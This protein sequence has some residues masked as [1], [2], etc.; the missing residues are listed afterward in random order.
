[1]FRGKMVAILHVNTLQLSIEYYTQVLGFTV[2]NFVDEDGSPVATME[3]AK[4]LLAAELVAGEN[5]ITLKKAPLG[6]ADGSA[7]YH[8]LEVINIDLYHRQVRERGG[9][10]S[11]MVN[12]PSGRKEFWLADYDGHGWIFY[13]PLPTSWFG[14]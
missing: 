13:K 14:S 5:Q 2:L 10:P 1:M 12:Q 3:E 9:N 4:N 11:E 6:D 7:V 8:S